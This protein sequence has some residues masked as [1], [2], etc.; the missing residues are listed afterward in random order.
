[1]G[2][3]WILVR[4]VDGMILSV[5]ASRNSATYAQTQEM[6]PSHIQPWIVDDDTPPYGDGHAFRRDL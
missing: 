5:H 2:M 3:V 4:D 1:M 6:E